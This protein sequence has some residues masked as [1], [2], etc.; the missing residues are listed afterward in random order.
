MELG[1]EDLTAFVCSDSQAASYAFRC[2]LC[3][4]AISKPTLRR[5]VDVLASSGVAL[6]FWRLPAESAEVHN[7]PPLCH[8]DMLELHQEL[9]SDGWFDRVTAMVAG[10][11]T[12]SE[13]GPS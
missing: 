4:V 8:D 13:P 6:R 3:R 10:S 2:P 12:G 5:V 1:V 11:E 9:E 7:G